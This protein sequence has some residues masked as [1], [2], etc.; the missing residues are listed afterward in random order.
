MIYAIDSSDRERVNESLSIF[1][2]LIYDQVLKALPI[3]M[4]ITKQDLEN[5]MDIYEL[6]E[7]F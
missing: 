7:I 3:L 6:E 2:N 1:N 4:F 5:S